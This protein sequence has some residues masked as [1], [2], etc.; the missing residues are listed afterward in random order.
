[1]A[2]SKNIQIVPYEE[3]E[4]LVDQKAGLCADTGGLV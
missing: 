2:P 3:G 1:M 4:F